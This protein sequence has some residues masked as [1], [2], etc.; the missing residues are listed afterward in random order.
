MI[1]IFFQGQ[2]KGPESILSKAEGPTS[3]GCQ[4]FCHHGQVIHFLFFSCYLR[5]IIFI[6]DFHGFWSWSV[7][8]LLQN[9]VLMKHAWFAWVLTC[10]TCLRY[11]A[12]KHVCDNTW[13][14]CRVFSFSWWLL[15]R[16]RSYSA[17]RGRPEGSPAPSTTQWPIPRW[18]SDLSKNSEYYFYRQLRFLFMTF[19][20]TRVINEQSSLINTTSN[21]KK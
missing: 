9:M 12:C 14:C 5:T 2:R 17:S 16:N 15:Q 21:W 6:Q 11:I 1:S 18:G 10:P 13:V 19:L 7:L 8:L 3:C 20:L 4:T